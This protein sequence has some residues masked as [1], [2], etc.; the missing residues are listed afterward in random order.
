M[1][2]RFIYTD[3]EGEPLSE[4]N[5]RDKVY[6]LDKD[7]GD[8]V[9]FYNAGSFMGCDWD[10]ANFFLPV[11]TEEQLDLFPGLRLRK[12]R[13]SNF[14]KQKREILEPIY[15]RVGLKLGSG[16]FPTVK[17]VDELHEL[18]NYC[19]KLAKKQPTRKIGRYKITRR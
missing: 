17:N 2:N 6:V 14:E 11:L 7:T 3:L 9:G 18:V 19:L 15:K 5:L 10:N 1:N 13:I 8:S 12:Y 4:W 16:L